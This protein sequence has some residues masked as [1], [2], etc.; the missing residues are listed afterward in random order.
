MLDFQKWEDF[1]PS[2]HG[3]HQFPLPI[4]SLIGGMKSMIPLSGKMD[5]LHTLFYLWDCFPC[6]PCNY[7]FLVFG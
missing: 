3:R 6:C 4:C 7:S 2:N 5:L 1:N